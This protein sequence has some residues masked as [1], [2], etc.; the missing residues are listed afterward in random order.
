MGSLSISDTFYNRNAGNPNP[1]FWFYDPDLS[2]RSSTTRSG[3]TSRCASRGRRRRAT[4]SRFSGTS[5]SRS[6]G[7]R[8]RQPHDLARGKRRTKV[9]AGPRIRP[10]GRRRCRTACSSRRRS[11]AGRPLQPGE[12]GNNK[13]VPNITEQTGPITFGSHEWRPTVLDAACARAHGVRDRVAQYEGRLRSLHEPR[14]PHVGDQQPESAA[15]GSKPD[16]EPDHDARQRPQRGRHGARRGVLRAG[17]V[18]EGPVHVPGGLRFDYGSSSVPE[19]QEGPSRWFPNPIVFPAQKLVTGYRDF[20][21]RGGLAWDVF[22]TGKTSL[23]VSGGKHIETVQWDG[24]Y[25]DANPMRAQIGGREPPDRDPVVDRSQRRLRPAVRLPELAGQRRVRDDVERELRA[26]PDALEHLR[27]GHHGWLGDPTPALPDE[28]LGAAGS[29]PR[30]SVEAGYSQRWFPVY[31][32][33]GETDF[34]TTTDNRA[35]T[36]ADYDF[37]ASRRRRIR[38]C[39]GAGTT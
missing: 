27:P 20:S 38:A 25:I 30:V 19:Q 28:C 18:D 6:E 8:G 7:R 39:L 12:A 21:L 11:R 33:P 32:P 34:T 10:C 31:R 17:R 13:D 24:I 23:K 29:A 14:G 2:R 4:S 22:G 5:S 35:V 15:P 9:P 37:S 1:A 36:P 26:G 16:T 3:W